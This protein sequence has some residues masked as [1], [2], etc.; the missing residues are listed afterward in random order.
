MEPEM[1]LLL[2]SEVC[3]SALDWPTPLWELFFFDLLPSPV[4]DWL[5]PLLPTAW[6]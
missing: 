2:I 4:S 3:P 5:D 1:L 6:D